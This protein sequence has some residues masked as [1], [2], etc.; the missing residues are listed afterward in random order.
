M[1]IKF[2]NTVQVDTD[3]LYV[4]AVNNRVGIGNVAPPVDLYV[5]SVLTGTNG[6]GTFTTDAIVTNDTKSITIGANKRAAWGMN[7]TTPTST[8]FQSKLNIWTGNSDHITFGGSSTGIVTAW[9]EFNLWINNDSGNAGTLHLYHT[10]TKTEFARF[11][12]GGNS[13]LNGGNVGIGTTAPAAKLHVKEPSGSTS[14]IK[15]SA[16][17]NEANYGY[18]T[19]TDNTVNT[20]KLTFGT[21]YGY[22]TPVPAM[23]V[24]NGMIGIGTTSPTAKLD[25]QQDTTGDLLARVWNT[26]AS[27]TGDSILRIANSGNNANGNRIEFSDASYYTATISADRSQGIVFRTSATG[28]NPITIP[29]RMRITSGGNVGIGTTNPGASLDVASTTSDYVAKFS[30][31]TATGYAPGSI[32]LQAGQGNS[33]GQG[34]YHYNTEADENWFTGVP[35]AVSSQKWIVANKSSTTQDVDTAQLTYALMTIASDTGNVG[36]GVTSPAAKLEVRADGWGTLAEMLRFSTN[37][38]SSGYVNSIVSKQSTGVGSNTILGF[39]LNTGVS[40]VQGRVLT[41]LGDGNVGIGTTSP[42]YPLDVAGTIRATTSAVSSYLSGSSLLF[43]DAA[44]T[45][46]GA[47]AVNFNPGTKNLLI[48]GN[49]TKWNRLDIIA[50]TFMF[51]S[52]GIGN[53]GELNI[54]SSSMDVDVLLKVEDQ[55]NIENLANATIDTD[56]FL[57]SDSASSDRVKY[58]TGA[59]VL[60]DIGGAPA[61]GGAYLPLAGGTMTGNTH[62]NDSA[63]STWGT[64]RDLIIEHDGSNSYITNE[65]RGFNY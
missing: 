38:G 40:G 55:I 11:A 61:T 56:R 37:A 10:N 39:D 7:A 13:W 21:T 63:Q 50:N 46:I 18:L 1:A 33:R 44:T 16:A 45:I 9:E 51:S 49:S 31:S 14:Q 41:L 26:N 12:G 58:R 27:G 20:A 32:L 24:W 23:T 6:D 59:Q 57:V 35:Y 60:S 62:H 5:G 34:L 2:L 64:G 3:V 36:I 43:P 54:S 4:D 30:H 28:S 19:M 42:I 22:N 53:T 48:G 29:E 25:I 8:T 52:G 47:N 17:S 65:Y 15:M